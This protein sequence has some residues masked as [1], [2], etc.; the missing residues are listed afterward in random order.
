MCGIIGGLLKKSL[1][2]EA[3]EASLNVMYHRGPDDADVYQDGNVFL[4]NRRLSIIDLSG[5]H[6]PVFNED[7]SVIVVFNGE[8]YNYLELLSLL[9]SKGHVFKTMSDTECLVHMWEEYGKNMCKFLR[10]MFAFAIWDSHK[11]VLFVARDR[12]GKKPLY[13]SL[14]RDGGIL[15][16]SEIKAL[17][18]LALSIG[19]SWNIFDQAVYHYLSLGVIPQPMTIYAEVKALLPGHWMS[20]GDNDLRFGKYWELTYELDTS[21]SY[22]DAIQKTRTLIAESVRLRLRSDVPVGLFLSGGLDSSILALEAEKI[23]GSS[24]HTFTVEVPGQNYDESLSAKR[25]ARFLGIKNTILTVKFNLESD[26]SR[27]VATYDQ[28]YADSSAIVTLLISELARQHVKVVLTGDGGDELFAG[29][30][31]HVAAYYL[32]RLK[33]RPFSFLGNIPALFGVSRRSSLGMILRI[34]RSAALEGTAQYLTLSTDMLFEKEKRNNWLR[35]P[36][37]VTET[38]LEG[39]VSPELSGLRSTMDTDI[40]VNLLSDLLVKMD[41]ATMACSLEARSPLLDHEL[42]EFVASLPPSY[43]VHHFRSK[44]L[45]RDAYCPELPSEVI[46]GKKRGFEIPLESILK[47]E[48]KPMVMDTLG[49][50]SSKV[51][52]YLRHDFIINLLSSRVLRDRNWGYIV[53]SLLILELWLQQRK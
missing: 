51:R 38:W 48:L 44:A 6:Q 20:F 25:T 10:G 4:G 13:Y 21:I 24:L 7:N 5:G 37:T 22:S 43:L 16:A 52:E 45:L 36:Q 18:S 9:E 31:R 30:R 39:I 19:E 3:I 8:I 34:L 42:A 12:F 14:L 47:N 23:L 40:R 46:K 26:I 41:M 28:P 1:P 15:F 50:T 27:I 32:Q 17:K 2:V 49:S 53:Y 11:R 35:E 29:Y 33:L